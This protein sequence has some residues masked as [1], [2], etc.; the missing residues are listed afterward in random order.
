[1]TQFS[2]AALH[3]RTALVTGAGRGIG[4]A[5]AV[6]LARDGAHVVCMGRTAERLAET[7]A[8]IDRV[9][10]S[11]EALVA[12][13]T[14]PA[15][16]A[17]LDALRRP[18][19]VLVNNAAAFAPYAHL[20]RVPAEAIQ[21]VLDTTLGAPLA[22]ARHLIGAMK[23]RG[24]GRVVNIGTIAGEVGA[25]GQVAYSTAKSGL[26]G[27]TKSLAAESAPF[28]VTVNLVEPG[29]IATER[30]R[31]NVAE[32]YQRR[33]LANTAIGRAGTPEEVAEVVAF[34]CSPRASYVTGAVIPVSGGLG[35]GLYA[36][37]LPR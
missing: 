1:M 24:F 29:L 11:G 26:I 21:T 3:G 37:E 10:G 25:D 8:E 19:D 20:E 15:S 2:K 18:I 7:V 34:L 23:S 27:L 33:I 35:V 30:I 14:E 17:A 36:R 28:G 6:A 12:D 4:R 13:V 32:E 22:L 16:L 5:I 9:S 31:E